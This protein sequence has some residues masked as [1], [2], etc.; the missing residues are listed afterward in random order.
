MKSKKLMLVAVLMLTAVLLMACGSK[1]AAT[2]EGKWKPDA[3]SAAAAALPEGAA[4]K[5]VVEFT[6]DGKMVTV[7]DGKSMADY[8]G[9]TLKAAGMSEEQIK[10]TTAEYPEAT[11][12]V[13]GN[14]ITL[15]IKM[16]E[17][18]TDTEGTFKIEGDKLTITAEGADQVFTKV[19]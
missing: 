7:I 15:T 14:K 13:D 6:K 18:T 8:V 9:E 16:G 12:K 19:K 5:T 2:I 4:D 1:P 10:A 17:T 3:K 11:Y